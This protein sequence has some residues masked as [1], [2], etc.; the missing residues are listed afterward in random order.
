MENEIKCVKCARPI[1]PTEEFTIV[2]T[3]KQGKVESALCPE[4]RVAFQETVEH[5]THDPNILLA[6][7]AGLLGA[8]VAGLIWYY[9]VTITEFQFGLVSVLMGW[10]V[11]RAVVWGAG[12]KRGRSLQIMSVT[13][14]VIAIFFSEYLI[15]NHYFIKEYGNTYGN[16]TFSDFWRVY[17]AYFTEASGFFNLVF[18]A[19]ALWQ[20]WVTPRTREVGGIVMN[21]PAV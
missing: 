16:L 10:L 13:L 5:E 11:G 14:T 15:L 17:R 6:T 3:S 12:N 7:G 20:A 8:A 1:K 19:I 9:F 21:R 4:C 2:K 18:Y